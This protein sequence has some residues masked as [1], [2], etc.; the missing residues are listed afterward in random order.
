MK[1]KLLVVL[2]LVS[3]CMLFGCKGVSGGNN[4]VSASET[5]SNGSIGADEDF[6][7]NQVFELTEE[8]ERLLTEE[9]IGD[10]RIKEGKLYS[11][12][13]EALL[14][15]RYARTY[16]EE[17]YPD[18]DFYITVFAPI[19]NNDP[20]ANITFYVNGNDEEF[21]DLELEV[22][23]DEYSA[24]DNYYG[25]LLREEYD[26]ALENII[27]EKTNAPFKA[28]TELYE[29]KGTEINGN[30]S[31]EELIALRSELS[32]R[33]YLFFNESDID[34]EALVKELQAYCTECGLYGSYTVYYGDNL[35]T[36]YKTSVELYD[37]IC[38]TSAFDMK[39]ESF[40]CFDVK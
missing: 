35:L 33:T 36:E 28:Y 37:F 11:F 21:Y 1:K 7:P 16:L 29:V 32:R 40:N 38:S 13:Y 23:G 6:D 3:T 26:D 10:D 24:K 14:Q 25:A 20:V 4:G 8:E 9:F 12:Q 5:M 22:D 19:S 31:V 34:V 15:L 39:R 30:T 17:K 18:T 2:L 27:K